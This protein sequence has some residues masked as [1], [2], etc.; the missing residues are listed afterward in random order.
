V[1][2]FFLHKGLLSDNSQKNHLYQAFRELGRVVRTVFLLEYISDTGLR[3][4][5]TAYTNVVEGYNGFL[6]W[7]FFD[8]E[9]IITENDPEEQGKRIKYLDLVA[10]AVILHNTVDVSL[11]VQELSAKGMKINRSLLATLSPYLTRHLRRYGEFVI[12]LQSIPS[13][14]E[15]AISIQIDL[16]EQ[17]P[18]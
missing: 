11:V 14:L 10:S 12:D 3:R 15:E 16:D 6:D 13:P 4:K 9:G 5:I 17:N 7:I 1:T 8:K 2:L 18:V